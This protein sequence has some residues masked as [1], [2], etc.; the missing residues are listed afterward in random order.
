MNEEK[1]PNADKKSNKKK[2]LVI[3][4]VTI[5][6]AL[7]LVLL[8]LIDFDALA[9]KIAGRDEPKSEPIYF[10]AP[11]YDTDILSDEDY[12]S[13]NR[14][15]KYRDGPETFIVTDGNYKLFGD[16]C[17]FFGRY[18]ESMINGDADTYNSL[19]SDAYIK[20]NGK[21]GRFPMQRV[22]NMEVTLSLTELLTSGEHRG[23]TRRI[24][25]VDYM[26]NMND[27]T[28]RSD[29]GSDGSRTLYYELIT[30]GGETLINAI[31]TS[32]DFDD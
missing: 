26:I 32:Y 4:I 5:G 27:G 1:K 25:A 29:V 19:F 24:F 30:E 14:N 15:L 17:E 6:V 18:F 16:L 21:K 3:V 28:V 11:D 23:A 7:L 22:Y 8:N 10:Y 9:A 20:E 12:L 31:M 13:L 2:A